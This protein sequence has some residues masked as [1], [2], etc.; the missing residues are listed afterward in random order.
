MCNNVRVLARAA[1]KDPALLRS[2]DEH[3]SQCRSLS[4]VDT[5]DILTLNVIG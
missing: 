1:E 5:K 4:L 2:N 3:I